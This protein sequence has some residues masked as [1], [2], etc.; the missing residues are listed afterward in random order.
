M[1]WLLTLL[2]TIISKARRSCDGVHL[3]LLQEAPIPPNTTT[4]SFVH[5]GYRVELVGSVDAA[6]VGV[7]HGWVGPGAPCPHQGQTCL[8]V[9]YLTW[10]LAAKSCPWNKTWMFCHWG[11]II[12]SGW[13]ESLGKENWYCL[14][15][16]FKLLQNTSLSAFEKILTHNQII[17]ESRVLFF[18]CSCSAAALLHR[19][20]NGW[21]A[22]SHQN[23]IPPKLC[24]SFASSLKH[25]L[26][27]LIKFYPFFIIFPINV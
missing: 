11:Y 13:S 12:T 17:L 23:L 21:E 10:A 3:V 14:S 6:H 22:F 16:F 7:V 26:R 2:G 5:V 8:V 19:C 27:G 24:S 15:H 25:R 4:S 9:A 1:T 20:W 18:L